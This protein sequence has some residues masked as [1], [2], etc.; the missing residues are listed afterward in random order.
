MTG[1]Y[2][3]YYMWCW[4]GVVAFVG[5]MFLVQVYFSYYKVN[6]I[7]KCLGEAKVVVSRSAVLDAGFL[8][9]AFFVLTIAGMFVFSEV[10]IK[11]GGFTREEFEQVPSRLKFQL[12]ALVYSLFFLVGFSVALWAVGKYVGW[13]G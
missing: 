6:E 2:Y 10:H 8:S 7:L 12:K 13:I 4:I 9:R 11:D 1:N 5:L 3:G